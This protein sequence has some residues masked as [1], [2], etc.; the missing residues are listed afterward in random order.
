MPADGDAFYVAFGLLGETIDATPAG[1]LI[2]TLRFH[3]RLGTGD[4]DARVE[5]AASGGTNGRT[6]VYG[7]ARPNQDSTG[8][9]TGASVRVVGPRFNTGD[10]NCDGSVDFN[11]INAFVAA[12][13]GPSAYA[14][15]FPDCFYELGDADCDDLVNFNDINAFV[16]CLIAGACESC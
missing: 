11:D 6:R 14:S 13:V 8:I 7:A 9:L 2:T 16:E 4:I 5:L 3:G 12:L 1:T 15:Q 10:V